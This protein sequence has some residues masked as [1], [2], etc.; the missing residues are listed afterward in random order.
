MFVPA[1]TVKLADRVGFWSMVTVSAM[2]F[3]VVTPAV[4]NQDLFTATEIVPVVVVPLHS[5]VLPYLILAVM[6]LP[7]P[8]PI[9]IETL[10]PVATLA[11]DALRV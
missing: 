11:G 2:L 10:L 1:V 9:A 4:V 7:L 5:W 3:A 8:L 6:L